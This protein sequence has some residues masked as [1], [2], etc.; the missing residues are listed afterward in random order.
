MHA[1]ETARK[2]GYADRKAGHPGPDATDVADLVEAR[3]TEIG[4]VDVGVVTVDWTD[5]EW[6]KYRQQM[7]TIHREVGDAYAQGADDARRK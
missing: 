6:D 1:L 5:E 4:L 2:R 3:M 7:K